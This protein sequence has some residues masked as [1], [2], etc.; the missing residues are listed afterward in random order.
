MALSPLTIH[1]L[2]AAVV[3]FNDCCFEYLTAYNQ[4]GSSLFADFK[5]SAAGRQYS[6]NAVVTQKREFQSTVTIF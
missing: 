5:K 4:L 1:T 2:S 3:K 6:D